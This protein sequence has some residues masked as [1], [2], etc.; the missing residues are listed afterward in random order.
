MLDPFCG[1]GTAVVAAENLN[2]KWIGI[3][4]TMIAINLMNRRLNDVFPGIH[5]KIDGEPTDMESAIHFALKD[6]H[7]FQ[8]WALLR[9]GAVPVG[10]TATDPKKVKKG[11]DEGYDGW[12]RFQDGP[13]GRVE[14]I[15]V[16]VRSGHV[17]LR[18]I[19]DFRDVV[20]VKKAA[21][22]IFITLEPPT[23]DMI[24]S[25]RVTDPY[26]SSLQI[27]YPKLQIITVSQLLERESPKL[28]TIISPFEEA[29][30]IRRPPRH[31]PSKLLPN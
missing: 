30:A 15:L 18:D 9:I 2:R 23:D 29:V 11:A 4:I 5:V 14:K 13:D 12:M 8:R 10:A 1:C 6:R 17:H 26:I 16:Q 3:D 25:V 21:M 20:T 24:R 27:E 7:E 31:K 22:G 19:R 28:P